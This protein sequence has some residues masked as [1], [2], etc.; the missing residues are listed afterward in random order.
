MPIIKSAWLT[1]VALSAV[2]S[3]TA[4]GSG[5]GDLFADYQRAVEGGEC[6]PDR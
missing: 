5:L 2:L 1:A 3:S 6:Q 4:Q